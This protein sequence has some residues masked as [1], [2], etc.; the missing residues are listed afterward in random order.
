M[1]SIVFVYINFFILALILFLERKEIKNYILLG[2]MGLIMG[3]IFEE[4]TTYFGMWYYHT[5]PKLWLVSIYSWIL[6][7]PYLSFCYFASKKVSK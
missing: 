1:E 4:F 7:F 6:Y 3:L 5:E 2:I